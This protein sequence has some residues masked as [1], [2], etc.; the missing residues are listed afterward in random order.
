M[1]G[2]VAAVLCVASGLCVLMTSAYALV[3][4]FPMFCPLLRTPVGYS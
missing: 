2:L 3:N 1:S 4:Y